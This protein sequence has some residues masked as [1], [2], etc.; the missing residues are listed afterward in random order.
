[1]AK[2]SDA[3]R[4]AF[5]SKKLAKMTLEEKVGQLLTFTRRGAML[6][7]SGIEQITKLQCGGLC[8]EPYA[9]ETCKN[10]YWGNSQIDKTFKPPKDYF[11]IANT[12]FAGKNFGISITPGDYTKDLNKLQKIAM[13]RPSGIPL[14]MTIDFE[15]DFKNDYMAGGIR[16][17]PPPM[18]MAAIGDPK[19]T[20][21]INNVIAKQLSNIGVT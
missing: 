8:L 18:G 15:G 9:V 3:K 11:K 7:P 20:Y 10:L 14:H 6:T 17:F 4:D 1:M 19:L 12:Y 5:V 16:Q 21:K 13:A 2:K